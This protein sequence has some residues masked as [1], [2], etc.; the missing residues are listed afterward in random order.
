MRFAPPYLG[1]GKVNVMKIGACGI[2]CQI[3][4]LWEKG[5][6]KGCCSGI[7]KNVLKTIEWLREE[8]GGCSVL[9]CAC[10]NKIDFCLR[11]DSFPCKLHYGK[12]PY[13]DGFLNE[14]KP[15]FE[16]AQELKK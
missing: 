5:F 12:G 2:A 11:C 14:L 1:E 3:C 13:K 16:K 7:D 9:E 10:K 15:Y 8:I 4:T 6:C